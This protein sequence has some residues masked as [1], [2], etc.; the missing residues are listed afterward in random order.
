MILVIVK[1]H[2]I[3]NPTYIPTAITMNLQVPTYLKIFYVCNDEITIKFS[4]L[5]LFLNNKYA[6]S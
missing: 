3:H 6:T 5:I 1:R 4:D 2:G